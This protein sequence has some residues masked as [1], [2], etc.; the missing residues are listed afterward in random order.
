[1]TF[2][3]QENARPKSAFFH[4]N[5][6]Q[7]TRARWAVRVFK[8]S[9]GRGWL[10]SVV[11]GVGLRYSGTQQFPGAG[12]WGCFRQPN[13]APPF[14]S[15]S[16]ENGGI[17]R[18]RQFAWIVLGL[19]GGAV[20]AQT[21][22]MTDSFVAA[23]ADSRNPVTSLAFVG[24]NGFHATW[25]GVYQF[26]KGNLKGP[27]TSIS[28]GDCKDAST[29]YGADGRLLVAAA[30][31]IQG[32]SLDSHTLCVS[33]DGGTSFF[34]IDDAFKVCEPSGA[35]RYQGVYS[36]AFR[37]EPVLEAV[38]RRFATVIPPDAPV[39]RWYV[40][41]GDTLYVSKNLN[42][43][44]NEVAKARSLVT[45]CGFSETFAATFSKVILL[46]TG[47]SDSPYRW[48]TVSLHPSQVPRPGVF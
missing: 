42:G 11:S 23:E 4:A 22:T 17:M 48:N 16:S 28:T 40:M 36:V 44:W 41:T 24:E 21:L 32:G 9:R 14:S 20:H 6:F 19:A 2:A 34:P 1:M 5:S 47:C 26:P 31:R 38:S 29:V 8:F 3:G 43:R 13:R 15:S 7:P 18:V 12:M 39:P 45:A 30:D 37:Q 35:C 25:K 46:T 10:N 27:Q 33:E